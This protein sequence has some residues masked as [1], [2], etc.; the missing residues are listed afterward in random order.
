MTTSRTGKPLSSPPAYVSRSSSGHGLAR[1]PPHGH[2]VSSSPSETDLDERRL[3]GHISD[4]VRESRTPRRPKPAGR[5]HESDQTQ[6]S[7]SSSS[8]LSALPMTYDDPDPEKK[9]WFSSALG[10]SA[11]RIAGFTSVVSLGNIGS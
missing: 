8:V 5:S 1:R 2:P 4:G 9:S 7:Q 11:D 10:D 6:K 3:F